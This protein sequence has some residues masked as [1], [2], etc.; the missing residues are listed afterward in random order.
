MSLETLLGKDFDAMLRHARAQVAG[1]LELMDKALAGD[2][3]ARQ[4]WREHARMVLSLM[5][6]SAEQ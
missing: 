6:G 4:F 3:E 1:Q 2:E 5:A